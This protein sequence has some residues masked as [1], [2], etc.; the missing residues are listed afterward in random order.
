M[1]PDPEK[2]ETRKSN[3]LTIYK[4]PITKNPE[5]RWTGIF[6]HIGAKVKIKGAASPVFPKGGVSY[7]TSVSTILTDFPDL[8]K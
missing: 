6:C 5:D 8:R 1:T 3:Y 2:P 7:T 4:Y